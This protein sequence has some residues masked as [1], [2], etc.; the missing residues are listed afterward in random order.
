MSA[1]P[2]R[3][4]EHP[5]PDA[6]PR[7]G[8][9]VILFALTCWSTTYIGAGDQ[10]LVTGLAYSVPLMAI[11]LAHEFGHYIAARI[12]RVPASL[13]YF[14]PFPFV[15]LFGTLGAVIAMRG[16]I[17]SRNALLDIG[18]SG[19]L[20]GM[21]VAIPVMIIGLMVSPVGPIPPGLGE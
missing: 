15:S 2:A 18:A 4:S 8:L 10:P 13:P 20:A 14:L 9:S 7:Y 12:H 16:R 19:P 5:D 1:E 3:T 6:Q 17:R 21:V 11:L